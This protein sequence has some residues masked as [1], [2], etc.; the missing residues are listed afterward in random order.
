MGQKHQIYLLSD[1]TGETLDRIFLAIKSQ[2]SNFDYEKKEFVFIRTENQINKVIKECEKKENVI[3]LYT[4]VETKLAKYLSQICEKKKI[5][6]FGILGN[7]ILNFSK[8]LNQK[9]T[10]IPS[11]QHVL[12]KDYYK[13]IEAI[14]FT[15][16]HDDGMKTEDIRNAEV[17]LLGV[18]RTS[19]TPTSIYLANRGYKTLNIPLVGSQEIPNVLKEDYN[20]FCVI[21]LV[22]E[23]V[24]LS[25]IRTNRLE[26]MREVNIPNYSSL[27]FVQKELEDSKKLFKKYNWPIID[28]TRKSVEETAASVIRIFEIKKGQKR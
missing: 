10:H 8:L 20:K 6:C 19:K 28:V 25:D 18:S 14:Q 11:A 4:V 12:D 13:R 24:R 3:I 5:P 17:I 22:V 2:F 1:S 27:E 26:I 7:L 15:M 21:G 9:A 16:A 23:A